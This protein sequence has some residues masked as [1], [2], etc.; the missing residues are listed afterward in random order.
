MDGAQS[1]VRSLSGGADAPAGLANGQWVSTYL[2]A[3][4]MAPRHESR[5][6]DR[7]NRRVFRLRVV[8]RLERRPHHANARSTGPVEKHG[9]RVHGRPRLSFGRPG[10]V[11]QANAVRAVATRASDRGA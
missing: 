9:R 1:D 2:I 8:H 5:V 7:G 4:R 10:A 6:A 11:E 3:N